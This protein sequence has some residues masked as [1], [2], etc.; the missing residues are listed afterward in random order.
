MKSNK[1]LLS[2]EEL[3]GHGTIKENETDTYTVFKA[4][5]SHGTAIATYYSV[6]PGIEIY[7]N[8]INMEE[9][10]DYGGFTVANKNLLVINH[11]QSGRFEC[12][13]KKGVLTYLGAGDLAIN[14][15]SYYDSRAKYPM[16]RYTGVSLLV[17]MDV[18]TEVL[19][20]IGELTGAKPVDL[21][22]LQKRLCPGSSCFIVRSNTVLSHIFEEL[23]SANDTTKQRYLSIKILELLL[24]LD[25]VKPEKEN[26][27]YFRKTQIDTI[28]SIE[29]YVTEDLRRSVTLVELSEKFCVPLTTMKICFKEVYGI[30]IY[31]YIKEYRIK[32]AA[33]MLRETS[34]SIGDISYETGYESPSK[35]SAAFRSIMEV[36]PTEYRKSICPNGLN[37]D[38]LG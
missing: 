28:K 15:F 23:Y 26:R 5:T 21:F 2:P 37:V 14:T 34:K 31:K 27:L 19:V 11:C 24:F 4:Q 29:K 35:F 36:T 16:I 38:F 20:K 6:M 10:A 7:Y 3:Y 18:A 22:A 12:E 25:S 30:S 8:D 1:M 17:D 33:E 9:G 32:I 13:F